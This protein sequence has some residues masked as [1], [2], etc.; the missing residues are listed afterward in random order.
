MFAIHAPAKVNLYLHVGPPRSDG[1]HPLD[2]LVIFTDKRAS[3]RLTFTPGGDGLHFSV[4]GDANSDQI[5]PADDNLV[6]RAVRQIEGA[7]GCR[8]KG[9]L[10][11][12]KRLPIAA[13]IGGGSADAAATLLLMNGAFK[14]GLSQQ[15]LIDLAAPLG[16]D[17]PACVAGVPVLMRGDGDR[18]SP[19]DAHLPELYAVLVTPDVSCPTGPVFRR[20]DEQ[21]SAQVFEE[22]SAPI[23]QTSEDL[24]DQLRSSYRNDLQSSAVSMFPVIGALI[25]ALYE[26]STVHFAA[27]SGS[28]ATCFAITHTQGASEMIVRE[29]SERFPRF[30]AQS[31][32]FGQAGF[33]P[34]GFSL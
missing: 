7:S 29:L 8:I 28:G 27:M 5:G 19:Y 18:V 34:E 11:L 26:Y 9:Q 4:S 23:A 22:M 1:R 21:N 30:W 31:V 33:D 24:C 32:R 3:D 10:Q 14:L 6:V 13:G 2:S 25:N 20:F 15:R 16:G 12:E 17:V